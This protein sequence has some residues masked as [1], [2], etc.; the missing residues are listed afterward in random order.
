M[1]FLS[2][3]VGN[4]QIHPKSE[5]IQAILNIPVPTKKKH[6]RS[7]LGSLNLDKKFFP[8]FSSKSAPLSDLTRK[9]SSNK[10]K[11][12]AEHDQA[13]NELK[14]DLVSAPVLWNPDF[15]SDSILKTDASDRGFDA[16]LLQGKNLEQHPIV[17]LSK[18]LLPREQ[19]FAT[20]EKECYAIVWAIKRLRKY[21]YGTEFVIES[22]HRALQWLKAKKSENPRL[23]R[24]SLV[25]QQFMYTVNQITGKDNKWRSSCPGEI[26]SCGFILND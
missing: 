11:W 13:F 12:I 17:Y 9:N 6:V 8:N 7:F 24:W 15:N 25:L 16:V 10:V 22:D 19:N 14:Q 26:T 21:L 2:H 3:V 23:L 20:V 5:K 4:S 18:K 1:E